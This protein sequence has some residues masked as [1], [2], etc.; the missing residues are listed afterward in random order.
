MA[1]RW[2][3]GDAYDRYM[4]RWSRIVAGE[5]LTWLGVPPNRRWLDVGCGTGVLTRSIVE[6]A[7]PRE[8]VG[9]DPSEGLLSHAREHTPGARFEVADG[10]SLP[11]ESGAFEVVVSG[12]ALNFV[13]EPAQA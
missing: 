1:D 2:L 10:R 5:F 6:Q 13:P 4:G 11:F 8:V 9:I 3:H 7:A 12:L